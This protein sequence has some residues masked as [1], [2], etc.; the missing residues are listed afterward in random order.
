MTKSLEN[1]ARYIYPQQTSCWQEGSNAAREGTGKTLNDN[2]YFHPKNQGFRNYALEDKYR[3]WKNGF[4]FTQE[5]MVKEEAEREGKQLP[6][7]G[8]GTSNPHVAP[9]YHKAS[10]YPFKKD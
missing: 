2:P 6:S 3:S 5:Q 4:L 10:S 7:L 9:E 8:A 1:I